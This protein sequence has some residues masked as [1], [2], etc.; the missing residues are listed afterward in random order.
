M[1]R[2]VVML[3]LLGL[4]L[5]GATGAQPADT[6]V[7][8]CDGIP[9][10]LFH[11]D[12]NAKVLSTL[13]QFPSTS[14]HYAP[15]FACMAK[16]NRSYR[17]LVQ[18]YWGQNR[19]GG[20]LN[21]THGGQ[22]TTIRWGAPLYSPQTMLLDSDGEWVLLDDSWYSGTRIFRITRTQITTVARA[23]QLSPHGMQMDPA[24]GRLVVRGFTTGPGT[25]KV[26]YFW[27]DP[28]TGAVTDCATSLL[29]TL[30]Q[31]G[32]GVIPYEPASAT[33]LDVPG[34]GSG[35][36]YKLSRVYPWIGW[37]PLPNAAA[38]GR[39]YDLT[40]THPAAR[41]SA[42]YRVLERQTVP[43]Y[44]GYI[45]HL[46]A[47]GSLAKRSTLNVPLS[48]RSS[49]VRVGSRHLAWTMVTRPNG[50]T[51]QLSFPGFPGKPYAVGFSL[52]GFRPGP[53]LADGREIPLVPDTL[54]LVA[55]RG[56]IPGMLTGTVGTLDAQGT[57]SVTV[58]TNVLGGGQTGVKVWATALV[59]DAKAPSGIRAIVGPTLLVL[60]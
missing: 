11:V 32:A 51:L 37:A 50:R 24:T 53:V 2:A 47:D 12:D 6:F 10:A 44:A 19:L 3:G 13:V 35:G 48:G 8:F 41:S 23:I 36:T 46:N 54:T 25:A 22:V 21:V 57:A 59:L 56:G 38:L 20:I 43:P 28:I 1:V 55:L 17:L 29:G 4:V 5:A 31:D 30:A 9:A 42:P 7:C 27:I 16:G 14:L 52:T 45:T 60:R 26:G 39:P 33:L 58:D 49:L 40:L 34:Y 18:P 15:R